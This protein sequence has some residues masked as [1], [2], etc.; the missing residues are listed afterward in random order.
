MSSIPQNPQ[1]N[2]VGNVL[3]QVHKYTDIAAQA[4]L[5]AQQE[6]IGQS[7]QTKAQIALG[8]VR[9]GLHTAGLI[10]PGVAAAA[11]AEQQLEPIMLPL[12]TSLVNIF[13]KHGHPEFQQPQQPPSTDPQP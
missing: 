9:T 11:A 6:G 1:Q 2:Q 3:E 7:G 8:I 5:R 12:F 13:R 4:V 10:V